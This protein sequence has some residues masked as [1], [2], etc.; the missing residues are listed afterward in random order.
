MQNWKTEYLIIRDNTPPVEWESLDYTLCPCRCRHEC[1]R[2]AS[3]CEFI[4]S[5]PI[6]DLSTLTHYTDNLTHFTCV[7][8]LT[9][10]LACNKAAHQY[11]PNKELLKTAKSA[12]REC[13]LAHLS[14]N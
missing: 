10:K 14:Q 6:P 11:Q 4:T 3:R 9:I 5:L 12:T 8:I 1:E 2:P 7:I 13:N